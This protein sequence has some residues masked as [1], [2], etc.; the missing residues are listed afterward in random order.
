MARHDW[1]RYG[2]AL[3]LSLSACATH[4]AADEGAVQDPIDRTLTFAQLKDTPDT[5]RGK[6]LELGGEVLAA[7][8]LKEGTRLEV[9]QLPLNEDHEPTTNR[10]ATQGRFLAIDPMGVD[11]AA[12]PAG[13]RVTIVGEVVGSRTQLIDEMDYTYPLLSVKELHLWAPAGDPRL[14]PRVILPP[15]YHPWGPFWRYGY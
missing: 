1:T 13:T 11:P 4:Q 6:L 8:R 5:Y 15:T 9:L 3:L 12:L 10:L 7:K 14:P 2:C